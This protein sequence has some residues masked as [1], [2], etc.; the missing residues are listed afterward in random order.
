MAE[1]RELVE[2]AGEPVDLQTI[3]IR[4]LS[5]MQG[6]ERAFLTF[7][8][9]GPEALTVLDDR[10]RRIRSLL[11]G[12][13]AELE[14]FEESLRL[15]R[16]ELPESGEL[17]APGVVVFSCWALDYVR[18][19]PL[20]IPPRNLLWI[21]SSPYV[22]PLAELQD[23][24][25][26]FVVVTANHRE[27]RIHRVVSA[28]PL[29]EDRVRGDVKNHVKKG[30]WSQKRYQRRRENER[31]HYGK[32]VAEAL[33]R[34]RAEEPFER[35]VLLG[36]PEVLAEVREALPQA[37]AETIVGERSVDLGNGEN[38]E[39]FEEAFE[40][41]FEQEREDEAELWER[42]QGEI[43]RDGLAAAGEREVLAAALA[44]RVETLVVTRDAR[45]EGMRCRD[46]ELLA[47]AKPQQCPRCRSTSVFEVDLVNELVELTART[48][49]RTEFVDPLPGLAE[50]GHVA[51]LLRW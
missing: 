48:S 45:I 40:L 20:S 15:L 3:D 17:G 10:A 42:I 43:A 44:G 34:L 46:C 36:T 9:S 26:P 32:E 37:I 31:L 27:A 35:L 49:A 1:K 25:I 33:E 22:R 21:G 29:E 11:Q 23:E 30:G 6:P 12:E 5:E 50:L 19:Y 38:G 7:Y 41:Y 51:A 16:A 8:G 2:P 14:H 24:Y 39:L 18:R 4:G 13:D 47:A 28:V